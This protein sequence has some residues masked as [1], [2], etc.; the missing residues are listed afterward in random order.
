MF[1]K[2]FLGGSEKK[3]TEC[4]GSIFIQVYEAH[5]NKNMDL[6]GDM[7]PYIVIHC[8]GDK[9]RTK[10]KRNAGCLASWK[11]DE[12]KFEIRLKTYFDLIKI[13]GHD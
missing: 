5:F 6:I 9:Y 1:F 13:S 7:D 10:V 11:N 3:E 12:Q 8:N 4:Y 2:S